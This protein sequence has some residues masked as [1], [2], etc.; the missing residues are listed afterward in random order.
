M[1]ERTSEAAVHAS[2]RGGAAS[3]GRPVPPLNPPNSKQVRGDRHSDNGL[4]DMNPP[5]RVHFRPQ[6]SNRRISLTLQQKI[7]TAASCPRRDPALKP[8]DARQPQRL[9]SPRSQP[10]AALSG[11]RPLVSREGQLPPGLLNELN[12]VLSK[13]SRPDGRGGESREAGPQNG[14]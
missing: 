10:D 9:P 7:N 8:P 12:A 11:R 13:S 4:R 5:S 2:T 1:S 3:E 6:V 14:Q